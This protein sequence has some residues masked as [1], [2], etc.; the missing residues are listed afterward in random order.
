MVGL[1]IA[2]FPQGVVLGTGYTK[3]MVFSGMREEPSMDQMT[4]LEGS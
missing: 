3:E 2:A 4:P 1:F